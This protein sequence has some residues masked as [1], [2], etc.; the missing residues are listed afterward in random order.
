MSGIWEYISILGP[1]VLVIAG[2]I[3]L[4]GAS[5]YLK[6]ARFLRSARRQLHLLAE[7][8]NS[9]DAGS[10]HDQQQ[11]IVNANVWMLPAWQST[12]KRRFRVGP[13]DERRTMLMGS[14]G[15]LWQPERLLHKH[16]NFSMYAAGPNIAVGVGLLFTFGFLTVAL[17]NAAAALDSGNGVSPVAATMKLL[18]SAGGKFV[19]SL[20]GLLVSLVWTVLAKR[21]LR[22]LH[23]ASARVVQA[24][25][26]RWPPMAAEFVLMEQLS[27]LR[28]TSSKLATQNETGQ[29]HLGRTEELLGVSREQS[30]LIKHTAEDQLAMADELLTEAREQ[31]GVL[32]R[33]ETDLAVSIGKAVAAGFNPKMEEMT[34]RLEKAITELSKRVSTMNE[35][36]LRIM[37]ENFAKA[38]SATTSEEMKQFKTSLG[39]LALRLAEAGNLLKENVGQASGQL[40]SATGQMSEQISTAAHGLVTSVQGMDAVMD[41]TSDS[42]KD[43]DAVLSRAA[44]LG[45]QGVER[46]D[47][48]MAGAGRLIDRMGEVGQGWTEVTDEIRSLV[49]KLSEACDGIDE[50]S[51]E[52]RSVARAVQMAG[53]E[54]HGAVSIMRQ[55]L[56]GTAKAMAQDMD[57][58]KDALARSSGDLS[59][60]VSAIQEGVTQY[61]QQLAHLHQAMD[62]EM[63]KA[64]N[65]LG[66]AIQSLDDA[67]GELNDGLDELGR[68]K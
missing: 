2:L 20:A 1:V 35:D 56:E 60:V 58:V 53:P 48:S 65:G 26:D 25:E 24:I 47:A 46:L 52:Q 19:S 4:V 59:G 17:T 5:C 21:E 22:H 49:A 68:R 23:A 12:I 62:A 42:V 50:L 43:M 13:G 55:Q 32:K 36:A 33:F 39:E 44:A 31:T 45:A 51:Q 66:G 29:S 30:G 54:V 7:S 9:S 57:R 15:D 61:S 8:L 11:A 10:S 37:L 67:I 18:Q 14:V 16:F 34:A 63:A 64:I 6:M 3:L 41:K 40:V 28:S 38:I 27:L